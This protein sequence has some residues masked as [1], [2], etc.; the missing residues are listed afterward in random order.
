MAWSRIHVSASL[1]PSCSK[2]NAMAGVM[3]P[4]PFNTRDKVVRDR[5]SRLAHSATVQPAASMS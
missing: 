4:L 2:D 1:Q 3:P 5:P